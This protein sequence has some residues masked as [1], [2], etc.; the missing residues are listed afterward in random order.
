[1]LQAL[2]VFPPEFKMILKERASGMYQISS[3]YLART[4][5]GLS[6]LLYLSII[7]DD[8]SKAGLYH[9]VSGLYRIVTQ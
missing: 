7:L 1:M 6:T 4:S 2:F 9:N 8:L 5:S 3:Y